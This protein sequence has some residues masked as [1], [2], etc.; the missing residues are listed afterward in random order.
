MEQDCA[1]H[2]P[3]EDHFQEQHVL[4]QQDKAQGDTLV[5]V[6]HPENQPLLDVNQEVGE[7]VLSGNG[8]PLVDMKAIVSA[9]ISAVYQGQSCSNPEATPHKI[10]GFVLSRT[11][12][13][14]QLIQE[15]QKEGAL[16]FPVQQ[17][18]TEPGSVV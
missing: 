14:A 11:A 2:I 6:V 1:A 7:E 17:V 16:L 9:N 13:S 3:E 12:K 4:D 5:Q 18:M 8:L 10:C 15:L